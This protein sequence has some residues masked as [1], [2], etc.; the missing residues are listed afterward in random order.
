MFTV[1]GLGIILWLIFGI[2]IR[3]PSVIAANSL[4]LVLVVA[5]LTLALHYEHARSARH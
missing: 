4:S 5:I 3:S 1:F 2:G